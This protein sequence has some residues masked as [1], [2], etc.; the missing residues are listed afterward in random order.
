MLG[1]DELSKE[2]RQTVNRA[3]RL[4]RFFTQPFFSTE[5]FTGL[6]GKM[7]SLP[8]TLSGCRRILNDEFA[9]VPEQQLYMQG[10]L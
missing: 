9:Q 3:R 1:M 5:T 6:E 4:E 2:D 10:A 7:V 8:D